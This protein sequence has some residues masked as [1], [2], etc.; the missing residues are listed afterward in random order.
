MSDIVMI[1]LGKGW[2]F[3]SM[4]DSYCIIPC[5]KRRCWA[6]EWVP[7]DFIYVPSWYLNNVNKN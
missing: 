7:H 3:E 1:L 5:D 6:A 2:V 4:V